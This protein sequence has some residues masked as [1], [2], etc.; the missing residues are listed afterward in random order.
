M[1]KKNLCSGL[2]LTGQI[3]NKRHKCTR[4]LDALLEA[5][6]T[7]IWENAP[8]SITTNTCMLFIEKDK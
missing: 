3:C 4:Y 5:D 6:N 7:K 1:S 2:K 8:F